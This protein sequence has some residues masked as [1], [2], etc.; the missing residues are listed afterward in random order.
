MNP[1]KH[2]ALLCL[3]CLAVLAAMA[4]INFTIDPVGVFSNRSIE[5]E[6]ANDLLAGQGVEIYGN[7]NDRALQKQRLGLERSAA[8]DYLVLG[9]S[10]A[11]LVGAWL[12]GGPTLNI[13]VPGATLEDLIALVDLSSQLRP[14]SYLLGVDPWI[15][16]RNNNQRSWKALERE[17]RRGLERI[18]DKIDAPAVDSDESRS[19]LRFS[20]LVNFEYFRESLKKLRRKNGILQRYRLVDVSTWSGP[21]ALIRPDGSRDYGHRA[22]SL[23]EQHE[24]DMAAAAEDKPFG[25][26]DFIALDRE[27]L[28]TFRKLIAYLHTKGQVTLLLMPYHPSSWQRIN[29]IAQVGTVE[30]EIRSMASDLHLDVLGSY[31][32]R[33]AGCPNNAFQDYMHPDKNCF[34]YIWN[35]LHAESLLPGWPQ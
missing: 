2:I 28:S 32:P 9:S 8:L 21:G 6:I 17:Y 24:L 7:V 15:F 19:I 33:I 5:R 13:A 30:V 11:M 10:R 22:L 20:Q 1:K 4:A 16:N 3:S 35:F 14:R 18:G 25:L 31:D 34:L 27:R 12:L 29:Q 23:E 26:K